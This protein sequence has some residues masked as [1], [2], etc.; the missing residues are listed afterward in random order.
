M[1]VTNPPNS[2]IDIDSTFLLGV[3]SD[4]APAQVPIGSSWMAINMVNLGGLWSCRP[5]YH[6]LT[7]FPDGTLQGVARF[8]P[9]VGE[10]QILVAVDGKI[11]VA[12]YP[13]TQFRQIPN[14]QFSP[15]A[16]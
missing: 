13:Y 16:R 2:T 9:L 3:N 12:S 8:H 14:L 7:T 4:V 11:Y 10:E 1:Q 5:G 15:A 6:C